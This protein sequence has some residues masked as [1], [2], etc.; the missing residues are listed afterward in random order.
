[1]TKAK[2]PKFTVGGILDDSSN[3]AGTDVDL[4]SSWALIAAH[5]RKM[6]YSSHI[7]V[8]HDKST[9]G[10]LADEFKALKKEFNRVAGTH[11]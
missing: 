4:T 11:E 1:M 9:L 7:E 3:S 8:V 2:R 6:A 10:R 5:Y